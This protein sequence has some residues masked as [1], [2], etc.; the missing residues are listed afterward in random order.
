VAAAWTAADVIAFAPEFCDVPIP[1]IDRTIRL[2]A[3]QVPAAC[4]GDNAVLGGVLLTCHYLLVNGAA[5]YARAQATPASGTV[6]PGTDKD[7]TSVTVGSVTVSYGGN[8][9]GGTVN[10]SRPASTASAMSNGVPAAYASTIYGQQFID[11]RKTLFL[12]VGLV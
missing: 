4:W 7:V 2:L 11:L 6:A 10:P 9:N 3:G 8:S 1:V 5:E 12:G